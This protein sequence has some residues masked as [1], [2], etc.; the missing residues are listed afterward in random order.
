MLL[1][2]ITTLFETHRIVV[3]P[4]VAHN[5]LSDQRKMHLYALFSIA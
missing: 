2:Y 1:L 5:F 4:A 3:S